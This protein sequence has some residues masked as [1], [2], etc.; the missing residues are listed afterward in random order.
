MFDYS[1]LTKLSIQDVCHMEPVMVAI[2]GMPMLEDLKLECTCW[3]PSY[4]T[5]IA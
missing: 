2:G 3:V 1:R 4:H 5:P